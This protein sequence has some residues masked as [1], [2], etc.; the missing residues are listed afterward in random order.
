MWYRVIPKALCLFL[1]VFTEMNTR[2]AW[3]KVKRMKLMQFGSLQ[4]RLF[5][6]LDD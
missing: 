4:F 2:R 5:V 1:L 3:E 6:N